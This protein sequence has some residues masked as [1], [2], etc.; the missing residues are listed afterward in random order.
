M[1][2]I[3]PRTLSQLVL[4]QAMKLIYESQQ[5]L[6]FDRSNVPANIRR[7]FIVYTNLIK[8]EDPYLGWTAKDGT[9]LQYDGAALQ[10][11]EDDVIAE[12]EAK[13]RAKR[14]KA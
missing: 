7:R 11:I 2:D 6:L 4:L 14:N 8:D 5:R 12:V 3:A 9:V 1:Q 13:R 10:Q